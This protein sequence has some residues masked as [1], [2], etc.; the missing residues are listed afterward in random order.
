M[1]IM[2][3]CLVRANVNKNIKFNALPIYKLTES[4][5]KFIFGNKLNFAKEISSYYLS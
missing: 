2:F 5:R 4:Q 3:H 1:I